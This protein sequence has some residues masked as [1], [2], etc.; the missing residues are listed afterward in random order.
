[1]AY[2]LDKLPRETRNLQIA[3]EGILAAINHYELDAKAISHSTNEKSPLLEAVNCN[4]L[5]TLKRFLDYS[6]GPVLIIDRK[7]SKI[8]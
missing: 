4:Q 6:A 7:R 5:E 8:K 1:M 3:K 2:L